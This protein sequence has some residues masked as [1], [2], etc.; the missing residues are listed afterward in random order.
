MKPKNFKLYNK[1]TQLAFINQKKPKQRNKNIIKMLTSKFLLKNSYLKVKNQ[2]KF[3]QVKTFLKILKE[4]QHE[5]ENGEIYHFF[6]DKSFKVNKLS[7]LKRDLKKKVVQ[8]SLR[9]ILEVI[10]ASSFK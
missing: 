5:L 4:L 3:L 8:E 6:N 10:Y 1:L 7:S 2:Y 9:I